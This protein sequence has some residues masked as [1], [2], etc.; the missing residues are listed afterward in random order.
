LWIDSTIIDPESGKGRLWA[1]S[2]QFPESNI[3]G[4]G[5]HG[6]TESGT[7][8]LLWIFYEVPLKQI[9]ECFRLKPLFAGESWSIRMM[10]GEK[11]TG[12]S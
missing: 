8:N 5:K 11:P 4:D 7:T 9:S 12:P 10:N 2:S 3:S 1:W 6:K